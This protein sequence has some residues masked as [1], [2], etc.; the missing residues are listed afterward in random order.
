M[1]SPAVLRTATV[2]DAA[3][4]SQLWAGAMASRDVA[5]MWED[6]A[7]II[8]ASASNSGSRVVVAEVEG[9]V[10]GAA[11]L[12]ATTMSPVNLQPVVQVISP[13]VVPHFRGRGLG[14]AILECA[15]AFAD[16]RGIAHVVSAAPT[17]SR[18]A[19]RFMARLGLRPIATLRVAAV[20]MLRS[21]LTARQP[22]SLASSRQLSQVLA[23]RRTSRRNQD[24]PV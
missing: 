20:P 10:V 11:Y 22:R 14:Q 1:R 18:E 8:C 24:A 7:T 2:D 12:V 17:G 3:L 9:V 5:T 16:E 13:N 19:N 21:K 15:V 6:A 23:A 4:V